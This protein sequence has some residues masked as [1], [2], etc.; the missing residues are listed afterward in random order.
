MKTA[1]KDRRGHDCPPNSPFEHDVH[2]T[3]S[4]FHSKEGGRQEWCGRRESSCICGTQNWAS[5]YYPCGSVGSRKWDIGSTS[6][7]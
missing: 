1:L 7:F 6:L 2:M 3:H 4:L 5:H